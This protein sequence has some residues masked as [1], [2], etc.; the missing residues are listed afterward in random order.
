MKNTTYV[1][2][3]SKIYT[4]KCVAQ[5][6]IEIQFLSVGFESISHRNIKHGFIIDMKVH[7][8]KYKSEQSGVVTPW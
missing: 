4:G 3:I 2:L 8:P 1:I 7:F 5:K 6:P